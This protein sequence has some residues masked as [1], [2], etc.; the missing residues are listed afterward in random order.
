MDP[1]CEPSR[2]VLTGK[3]AKKLLDNTIKECFMYKYSQDYV[4][5][6]DKF[7]AESFNNFMN[8]C[9]DKRILF[10]DDQNR[11]RSNLAV[12]HWNENVDRAFTSVLRSRDNSF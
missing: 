12:C 10:E 3:H 1:N 7:Y 9:Q 11:F 8:I 6:K 5:G 2:I 4:L